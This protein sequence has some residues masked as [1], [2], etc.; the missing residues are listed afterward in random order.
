MYSVEDDSRNG[1]LAFEWFIVS[2]GIDDFCH[3]VDVFLAQV[4]MKN[5]VGFRIR[6]VLSL[7]VTLSFPTKPQSHTSS[8]RNAPMNELTL[9]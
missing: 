1:D 5:G 4:M 3:E 7:F 2:L 6:T 8:K 9:K